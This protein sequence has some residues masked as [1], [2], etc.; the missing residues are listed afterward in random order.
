VIRESWNSWRTQLNNVRIN[1]GEDLRKTPENM[2]SMK[3]SFYL[4]ERLL[5]VNLREWIGA[6]KGPC[7][8]AKFCDWKIL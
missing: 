2:G 8:R 6:D 7:P 5:K 1:V 4:P 3:F